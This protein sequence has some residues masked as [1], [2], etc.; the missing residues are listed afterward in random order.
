MTELLPQALLVEISAA[1]HRT[2]ALLEL[3]LADEGLVADY[4][5]YSLLGHASRATP[6]ELA[7]AL[8]YPMSTAVSRVNRMVERG[9]AARVRN[10]RDGRSAFVVLTTAGRRRWEL[11]REGWGRALEAVRHHLPVADEE[12]T[13]VV[14]AVRT[15]LEAAIEQLLDE[16]YEQSAA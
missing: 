6:T 2:A 5:L 1:Y 13:A 9:D 12:A 14:S 16:R 7:R 15:A 10:P 11:S 4:A 8:G 3:T